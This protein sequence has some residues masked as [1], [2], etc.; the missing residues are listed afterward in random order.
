MK[1]SRI[2]PLRR[3]RRDSRLLTS[4]RVWVGFDHPRLAAPQDTA[5]HARLGIRPAKACGIGP[6]PS[7]PG[8]AV[9]LSEGRLY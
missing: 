6:V 4:A 1:R 3:A 8:V 9:G 2:A 7:H 5:E